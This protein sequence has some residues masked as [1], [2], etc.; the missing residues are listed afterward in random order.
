MQKAFTFLKNCLLTESNGLFLSFDSLTEL[1]N[2][3]LNQNN[4]SL[5]RCQVRLAGFKF[6]YMHFSKNDVE[7]QILIDKINDRMVSEVDF[8]KQLLYI[9]PFID[10]N[11]G[12]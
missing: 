1:N 2:I 3:I 7:L 6:E 12:Q 10:G 4:Y 9:H 5:R 11:E 8:L